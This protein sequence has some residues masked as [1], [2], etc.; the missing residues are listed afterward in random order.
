VRA[1]NSGEV[2]CVPWGEL[3][4]ADDEEEPENRL[5]PTDADS[6]NN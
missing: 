1:V 2:K 5:F 3:H 4:L 6:Q